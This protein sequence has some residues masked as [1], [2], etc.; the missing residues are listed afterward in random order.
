MRKPFAIALKLDYNK[1][2]IVDETHTTFWNGAGNL[3]T[4]F[5][6]EGALCMVA[7]PCDFPFG[8]RLVL[9]N[10]LS[11]LLAALDATDA[12]KSILMGE[13]AA[14]I[15]ATVQV[16]VYNDYDT[17]LSKCKYST[18]KGK[19]SAEFKNDNK[20]ILRENMLVKEANYSFDSVNGKRHGNQYLLWLTAS[21]I[22]AK[23]N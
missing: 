17:Y 11:T 7:L 9:L 6:S 8:Y 5:P 4:I 12:T 3:D 1:T 22:Y 19:F 10:L 16:L 13:P 21:C 2:L 18:L 23:I 20:D 15:S 14:G